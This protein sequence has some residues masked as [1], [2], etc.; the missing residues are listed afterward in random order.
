VT[1]ARERAGE[2]RV[3]WNPG[4]PLADGLRSRVELWQ[5]TGGEWP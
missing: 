1:A 4:M 2:G 5:P 3:K